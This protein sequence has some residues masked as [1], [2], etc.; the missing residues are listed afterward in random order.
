MVA[1]LHLEEDKMAKNMFREDR[2]CSKQKGAA[3]YRCPQH[4]FQY[5]NKPCLKSCTDHQT[6]L[7]TYSRAYKHERHQLYLLTVWHAL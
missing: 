1:A 2:L 7:V 5:K 4:W 3:P 6:N